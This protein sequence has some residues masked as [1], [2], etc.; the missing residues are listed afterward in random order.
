MITQEAAEKALDHLRDT[1]ESCARARAERL[2]LDEYTKSLRSILMS[3]HL[4][5]TLGAQERHALSDERYIKHLEALKEA[6]F[7]DERG[8]FLRE[9]ASVK[10][11]AWR[12]EQASL[13]GA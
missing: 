4:T 5:E 10:V 13:R 6:I 8:R 9:A 1:A 12:T 2:Y 7:Q 3:E 11:D